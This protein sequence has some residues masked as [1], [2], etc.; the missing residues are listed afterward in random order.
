[1]I[2][3]DRG[4]QSGSTRQCPSARCS[5]LIVGCGSAPANTRVSCDVRNK[6]DSDCCVAVAGGS[7][8]SPWPRN[9]LGLLGGEDRYGDLTSL[10]ATIAMAPQLRFSPVGE[11]EM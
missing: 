2:G 4:Q 6:L 1:M 7:T 3:T 5:I 10:V 9:G 11:A 8:E